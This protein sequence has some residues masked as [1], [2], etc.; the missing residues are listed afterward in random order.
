[1]LFY[2]TVKLALSLNRSV[3]VNN[4]HLDSMTDDILY[5]F[6]LGTSTHDLA[7]M[8]G[9]VK[10]NFNSLPFHSKTCL[11]QNDLSLSNSLG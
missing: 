11:L 4:P 10:V 2:V 5:H 6:N 9:D 3:Y 8:F 1:M 7:A